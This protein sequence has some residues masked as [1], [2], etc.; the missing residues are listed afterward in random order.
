MLLKEQLI[1]YVLKANLPKGTELAETVFL[2]EI[3]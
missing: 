3:K 1:K 2:G